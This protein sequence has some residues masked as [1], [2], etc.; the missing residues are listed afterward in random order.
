MGRGLWCWITNDVEYTEDKMKENG[1]VFWRK[2][3]QEELC[4]FRKDRS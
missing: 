2:K 4:F 3:L 1:E